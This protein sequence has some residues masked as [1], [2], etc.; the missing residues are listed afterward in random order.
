M[1]G[2][3]HSS[4]FP[5]KFF[6]QPSIRI[7]LQ[8]SHF[9]QKNKVCGRAEWKELLRLIKAVLRSLFQ[10]ISLHEILILHHFFISSFEFSNF[11]GFSEK[12]WYAYFCK[13]YHLA[14]WEILILLP[15]GEGGPITILISAFSSYKFITS[16]F[17]VS[18]RFRS[19]FSSM[20]IFEGSGLFSLS[21]NY[22]NTH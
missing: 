22:F 4:R 12:S 21:Y 17:I 16:H 3:W 15:L 10:N 11:H 6:R 8:F 18:W 7:P 14:H 1:Q 20:I 13:I 9:C 19:L 2:K 5:K